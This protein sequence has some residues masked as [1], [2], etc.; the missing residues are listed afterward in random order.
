M[1]KYQNYDI[2]LQEIPE[3]VSLAVNITNCQNNC[4][5]CHSPYLK[6]DIGKELTEKEIDKLLSEN[7]G[8]N[9]F[10]FMGEGNDINKLFALSD[11]VFNRYNIKTAIYCGG[12]NI[13][14]D[15]YSHFDYIKI[16]EYK[17]EFGP[18]NSKFT[19]QRLYKID[20]YNKKVL[21]DITYVFQK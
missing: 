5:G 14:D 15:F 19:N 4:I 10:L 11:Y 2:L 7:F 13:E 12:N 8:V 6:N 16:G 9:C 1:I 18:L 3:M 17:S 21:D 20:R